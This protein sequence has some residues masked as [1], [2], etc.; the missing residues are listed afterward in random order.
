MNRPEC[1]PECS[2]LEGSD[3]P[4]TGQWFKMLETPVGHPDSVEDHL[5]GVARKNKACWLAG[6]NRIGAR[7]SVHMAVLRHCASALA[8]YQV[9]SVRPFAVE[10][11]ARTHGAG[12]WQCL[13]NLLQVD[14][15]QSER[16]VQALAT[17]PMSLGGLRLRS[18]Q[19]SR[20]SGPV[21]RLVTLR[22]PDKWKDSPHPRLSRR[23]PRQGG[24]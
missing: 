4:T 21:G 7:C 2:G 1:R 13:S 10:N 9:I 5:Q 3:V 23:L 16:T 19:V 6:P 14:P 17:L 8:N 22:W 12:L 20:H 18:S 15:S 24:N 11:F